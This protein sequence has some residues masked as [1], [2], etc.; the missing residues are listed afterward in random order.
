MGDQLR[1]IF[2][3][4][5]STPRDRVGREIVRAANAMFGLEYSKTVSTSFKGKRRELD[6]TLHFGHVL[7]AAFLIFVLVMILVAT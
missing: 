5:W 7:V 4:Q 6:L 1:A 2:W 3:D